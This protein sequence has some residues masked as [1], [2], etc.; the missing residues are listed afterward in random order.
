MYIT[1]GKIRNRHSEVTDKI[2][3]CIAIFIQ[4]GTES[5]WP[6]KCSHSVIPAIA[7]SIKS[8]FPQIRNYILRA[9]IH[10]EKYTFPSYL[11]CNIVQ[12]E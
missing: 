1:L 9:F 2:P 6:T 12:I 10:S 4:D 5:I 3:L 8:C 7:C 11:S